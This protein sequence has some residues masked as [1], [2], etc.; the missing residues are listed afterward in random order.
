MIEILPV[1]DKEREKIFLRKMSVSDDAVV[2]EMT[3]KESTLGVVALK[4][5]EEKLYIL[6]LLAEGYSF[7]EKPDVE[8]NFILDSLVRAAASYGETNGATEIHISFCDFHDFMK[9]RG[10]DVQGGHAYAPM[11]LIVKYH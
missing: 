5:K 7:D 2:L 4:I 9:N 3:E 6:S 8:Q 1:S 10:F 11:S